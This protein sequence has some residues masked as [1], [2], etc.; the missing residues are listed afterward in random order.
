MKTAQ[1][2][3]TN[4]NTNEHKDV[5]IAVAVIVVMALVSIGVYSWDDIIESLDD[6]KK[7]EWN[8]TMNVIRKHYDTLYVD[9]DGIVYNNSY[10]NILIKIPEQIRKNLETFVVPEGVIRIETDAFAK[11]SNLKSIVIAS[12]VKEIG[13]YAFRNCVGLKKIHLPESIVKIGYN[14]FL[15]ISNLQIDLNNDFYYVKNSCL[16]ERK[17]GKLISYLGDAENLNLQSFNEIKVIGEYSFG[18]NNTLKRITLPDSLTEIG[19]YAFFVCSKLNSVNLPPMIERIGLNPFVG[20]KDIV[21]FFFTDGLKYRIKAKHFLIDSVNSEM[22]YYF[23][24]DTSVL[25]IHDIPPKINKINR[26]AFD[27]CRISKLVLPKSVKSIGDKIFSDTNVIFIDTLVLHSDF[28]INVKEKPFNE[29][30]I[31]KCPKGTLR[32]YKKV[33]PKN[34]IIEY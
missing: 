3:D 5:L 27:R 33:L 9:D 20:I 14:P 32:K 12:S 26:S 25:A 8:K 2:R 30:I 18:L 13:H 10:R 24:K 15:K 29:K 4:E 21:L 17:T 11:C 7:E 16:I 28:V 6:K 1:N 19:N 23:G 31:I 34:I 22:V